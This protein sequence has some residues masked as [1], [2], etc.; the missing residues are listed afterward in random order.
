MLP[1][2]RI[3][4]HNKYFLWGIVYLTD[5]IKLPEHA[6]S[7]YH[8]FLLGNHT[9][10]RS[11]KPSKFNAVSTDMALEQSLNRESKVKGGLI[12]VTHRESTVEKWTL[13]AHL[14]SAVFANL[15]NMCGANDDNLENKDTL[16]CSIKK[17]KRHTNQI[18]DI[19]NK[20]NP[21]DIA[22]SAD[23]IEPLINILNGAVPST[24]TAEQLLG[25]FNRGEEMVKE[26]VEKIEDNPESFWDPI[27]RVNLPTFDVIRKSVKVSSGK[28]KVQTLKGGQNFFQR[29]TVISQ[30]RELDL[31]DV[32]SYALAAVSLSLFHIDGSMRKRNKAALLHELEIDELNSE[33]PP[34]IVSTGYIPYR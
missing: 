13:T 22:T 26:F 6:P 18:L 10:S 23:T 19:F 31:V 24:Q 28:E 11:K 29:C 32:L 8:Q 7:V 25:A 27:K 1:Y 14:R 21:F 12:G 20:V 33:Y 34:T 2:N 15:K 30:K 17:S 3:F 5:M 9:V 16:Q 4:D